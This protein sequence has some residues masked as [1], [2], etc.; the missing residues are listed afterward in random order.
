MSAMEGLAHPEFLIETEPLERRL[1]DPGLRI[2][3]CTKPR[4]LPG[5]RWVMLKTEY[6]SLLN[7]ITIPGRS[8]VAESIR[9]S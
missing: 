6:N 4:R 2:F 8:C 3:A 5:V 9:V 7:L 1:K